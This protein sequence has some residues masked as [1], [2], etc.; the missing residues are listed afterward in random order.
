MTTYQGEPLR[1]GATGQCTTHPAS[2]PCSGL[3]ADGI[4][5]GTCSFKKEFILIDSE[6]PITVIIEVR[7]C[8]EL[9]TKIKRKKAR[10]MYD[11]CMCGLD[12]LG[13][14]G[15]ILVNTKLF[16]F[17]R[18]TYKGVNYKLVATIER[19]ECMRRAGKEVRDSAILEAIVSS[20]A[21][22]DGPRQLRSSWKSNHLK[23]KIL[24]TC[25]GTGKSKQSSN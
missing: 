25:T 14:W 12:G 24:C 19:A 23:Q 13:L 17:I 11:T 5:E 7:N 21:C 22:E 1:G 9:V 8:R 16:R 18:H 2:Q 15:I 20:G 10:G 4:R 6:T 3:Q